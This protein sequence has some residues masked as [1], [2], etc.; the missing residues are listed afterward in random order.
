[1][2]ADERKVIVI[3]G[4]HHNTLGVI[5]SL[6]MKGLCQEICCLVEYPDLFVSKSRYLMSRNTFV[7]K[8]SS[9]LIERVLWIA[10][11]EKI[12]PIVICCGDKYIACLDRHYNKISQYCILPNANETEG[13]I[14]YFMDKDK[15]SNLAQRMGIDTPCSIMLDSLDLA[16]TDRFIFPCIVKPL[17]SVVGSKKDI[18]ICRDFHALNMAV[19]RNNTGRCFLVESYI[20]KTAEFQLIGCSLPG[21]IIIPGYTKIIRQPKNTNTGYLKYSP[22]SDGFI[23]G[24]LLDKVGELINDLSYKGLFSVEFLRGKDGRD[25]F[26]EINMRND[27]NAFCA[28]CAGINLPYLWY[29]YADADK[30]PT[31]ID[32]C[33]NK[34]IYWMPEADLRNMLKVGVFKWIK[35]WITAAGHGIVS[36][37]DLKPFIYFVLSKFLKKP[38]CHT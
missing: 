12:K 11:P 34:T 27:G 30:L 22:I 14:A 15:Q 1:M 32:I 24:Q 2:N 10:K 17:N 26:L 4:S 13:Q 16:D 31:D 7:F 23:D 20:D 9:E 36:R 28:T 3:G 8:T 33:V 6:G 29:R 37:H 38:I 19:M 5:R 25:Y 21:K 35:Q 18:A